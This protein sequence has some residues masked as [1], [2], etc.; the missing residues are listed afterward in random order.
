MQVETCKDEGLRS[1]VIG[2]YKYLV[3][4]NVCAYICI[5][6]PMIIDIC[7]CG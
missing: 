7:Q 1:R 6:T 5:I 4:L 3:S 2:Y